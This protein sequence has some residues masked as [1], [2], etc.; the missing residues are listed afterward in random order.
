MY[1]SYLRWQI[2]DTVGAG[3]KPGSLGW[4][5]GALRYVAL[6]VLSTNILEWLAHQCMLHKDNSGEGK[7]P[8]GEAARQGGSPAK[9]LL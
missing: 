1:L 5:P 2:A 6:Y 8:A 3:S 7:L 9:R 4:L